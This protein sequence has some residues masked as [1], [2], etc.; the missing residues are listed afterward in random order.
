[1]WNYATN[2]TFINLFGDEY[3]RNN[4]QFKK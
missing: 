3:S 1:M 4:L 2:N